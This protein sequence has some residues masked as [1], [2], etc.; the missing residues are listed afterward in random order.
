MRTDRTALSVFALMMVFF[1]A[2]FP[3]LSSAQPHPMVRVCRTNDMWLTLHANGSIGNDGSSQHSASLDP[4]PPF[5]WAPQCEL[6]GGSGQQYLYFANLWIGA[7]VVE[8]GEE[9]PRVSVSNDGWLYPSIMEFW[10]DPE[11]GIVERSRTEQTNCVDEP[12]FDPNLPADNLLSTTFTD[13]VQ[14]A[15][16]VEPDPVDGPHFPLG[17]EVRADYYTM[18]SEACRHIYWIRY[19]IRNIGT[20]LLKDVFFGQYVDGDVGP[21]EYIDQH[22]DD[23]S[24]FDSTSQ[25][26][27]LCDNDGRRA[28]Q[29]DGPLVVPHVTGMTFL[30]VP[31]G[32]RIGYNWWA[33]NADIEGDYG[34]SWAAY[35]DRDSL[36][37]GWTQL[38]GTPMGDLRKYQLMSNGEWDFD[39][40]YFDSV[41]W[42]TAHPQNGHAWSLTGRP[43]DA[44]DL[45]YGNDARY[46]LSAG[47]F[48]TRVNDHTELAPGDSLDIWMAFV[49]G[50]NFHDP[51]HP[52]IV[53]T[54]INP[55]LFDFTDLRASSIRARSTVCFNWRGLTA[56]PLPVVTAPAEFNLDPVYPNPFNA[57][58]MI[59]FS[60]PHASRVDLAVF[61]VLGR[62]VQQIATAELAAGTHSISWDAAGLPSGIYWIQAVA[63][64]QTTRAQKAVLLR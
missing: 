25:V 4:C 61:D 19:R 59:R 30:S 10:P 31:A 5:A 50:L 15:V 27:Y 23:L 41:G 51:A 17:I 22:V 6:P 36:G 55:A 32:G 7:K 12:V 57:S 52:Q 64:R 18:S 54:H 49:G 21:M 39:Q 37:M 35:A 44:E 58:A 26:A 34:P 42:I 29:S 20:Q 16:Y 43:S 38:Y 46:L 56:D 11:G 33:S 8:N 14:S 2:A 13:T 60:L 28:E 3:A 9:R 24:G 48:G 1:L 63:G 45:A 62:K 47:P 53:G 40:V